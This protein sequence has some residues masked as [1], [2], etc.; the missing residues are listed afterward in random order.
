MGNTFVAGIAF[1]RI[2]PTGNP[3]NLLNAPENAELRA[4]FLELVKLRQVGRSWLEFGYLQRPVK[5]AAEVPD[6]PIK[7]PK[8]RD[9]SIKAVLDSAWIN[10]EGALAFV[11]VNVS[12]QEQ[13]FTWRADLAKYE[14]APAE[15]YTVKRLMPDGTRKLLGSLETGRDAVLERSETMPAHSALVVEVTVGAY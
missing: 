8:G 14:I 5:F 7:D 4:F 2:W 6:V 1:G 3:L 10:E 13:S 11:F 9:S 12:E 15:V